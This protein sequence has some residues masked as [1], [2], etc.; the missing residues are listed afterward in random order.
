[1]FL[2]GSRTSHDRRTRSDE[3]R[4]AGHLCRVQYY[5]L[6]DFDSDVQVRRTLQRLVQS[7]IPRS[8]GRTRK[9]SSADNDND[10]DHR[11][12]I[13]DL[14]LHLI[15]EFRYAKAAPSGCYI[16]HCD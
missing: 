16:T 7:R 12:E 9:T 13:V 11:Q 10:G 8:R 3:H 1:M 4:P 5:E 15:V 14:G 2:T 6:I